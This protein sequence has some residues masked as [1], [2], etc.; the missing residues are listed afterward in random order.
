M[1]LRIPALEDALNAHN[2]ATAAAATIADILTR[3]RADGKALD[4]RHAELEEAAASLLAS[5]EMTRAAIHRFQEID[6][7]VTGGF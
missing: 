5:A 7:R 3:H 2:S 1:A 4:S 6:K